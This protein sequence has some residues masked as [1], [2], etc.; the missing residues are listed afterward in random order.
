M[1]C[2]T[3]H[4]AIWIA[5]MAAVVPATALAQSRPFG[6]CRA[7]FWSSTRNLDDQ[8]D[9]PKPTCF[10]NWR[11]TLAEGVRLGVNAR[12]GWQD[13]EAADG[14][15]G[16]VREGYAELESGA[17]TAKLGRQII[18]WGRSDRINPTDGLSPRDFTLLV[19]EDEEQRNGINAA[20]LRYHV[21]ESLSV[22]AVV[23]QFEAHRIPQGALPPNLTRPAEP[24]RAEW[25][26]KVDHTGEG[27]DWSVSYFDGF[28]R[29]ARHWVEFISP[30]TPVF[31]SAYERAQTVGADFAAAAGGWTMR[32]EFS[33]SHLRSD[34]GSACPLP[35]RKV[36]RAVIGVDRDFW[37]TANINAQLFAV[38]RSYSDP[39]ST[40]AARQ[41]LALGLDRLNSEFGDREWGLT[42]RISDRFLNE[43]LKL[44]I[45]GIAD[46]T[47]RSGVLRPRATY[48]FS[49]TVKL[50]AGV[51]YFRGRTQSF[52][53][54]R[55]KNDTAFAELTLVY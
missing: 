3:V 35:R 16:R 19:P 23:A 28:D 48:A 36:A 38:A 13:A 37:D 30:T 44:E 52:F 10:V 40:P 54:S 50:G 42:L 33:Y 53:G 20:L 49:D 5:A 22:T 27:F 25:A 43:R 2:R 1:R 45:S 29:F 6:E 26:L 14:G 34:C 41:P 51:D 47:N 32:G 11:P 39:A 24:G 31:R 46:F 9:V 8:A 17:W 18:A 55:K 15:H 12:V 21:A 4:A 7:G